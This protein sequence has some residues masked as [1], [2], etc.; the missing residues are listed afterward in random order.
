MAIAKYYSQLEQLHASLG[1][2]AFKSGNWEKYN[3]Q[4]SDSLNR[5]TE[6][7]NGIANPPE[8]KAFL[9]KVAGLQGSIFARLKERARENNLPISVETG[10]APPTLTSRVIKGLYNHSGKIAFLASAYLLAGQT[11]VGSQMLSDAGKAFF[12]YCEPIK[13]AAV[14][15][16]TCLSDN[17]ENITSALSGYAA[18]TG[19]KKLW[20]KGWKKTAGLFLLA[21]TAV[22]ATS[23]ILKPGALSE[24]TW[25]QANTTWT[26]TKDFASWAFNSGSAWISSQAKRLQS[27]EMAKDA[28]GFLSTHKSDITSGA[29]GLATLVGA[30]K[31]WNKGWKKLSGVVFLTG[32]GMAVAPHLFKLGMVTAETQAQLNAA[33]DEALSRV[34]SQVQRY[35][36]GL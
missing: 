17:R 7:L 30:K 3:R 32:T 18:I 16:A 4:Y 29:T 24:E 35:R 34:S 6:L 9:E 8:R 14:Q 20:D 13:Q 31:L 2:G 21:G 26:K 36:D 25:A 28:K 10:Q 15:A 23:Q 19:A 12:Q 11:G 27:G 22:A 5:E 33:W 1:E